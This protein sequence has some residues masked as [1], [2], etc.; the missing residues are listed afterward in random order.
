MF[1]F[2]LEVGPAFVS[3]FCSQCSKGR[4]G[5]KNMSQRNHSPPLSTFLIS[6]SISFSNPNKWTLDLSIGGV[7]TAAE[8]LSGSAKDIGF[9][10]TVAFQRFLNIMGWRKLGRK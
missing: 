8:S 5:I 1:V 6:N 2:L 3:E 10:H 4:H 9:S 7:G